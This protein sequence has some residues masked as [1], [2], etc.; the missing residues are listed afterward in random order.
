MTGSTVI[1]ALAG[2]HHLKLP[3]SDLERSREWY[4]RVLGYRRMVEFVEDGRLM[5]LSLDHP[6]GGPPLALRL[7]PD[8]AAAVAGFDYFSIGVAD[9]ET[10]I[11]IAAR[12]D[13]FGIGHG[14]VHRTTQGWV[15]PLAHDPDGHEVRFYTVGRHEDAVAPDVPH[16]I[17]DPGPN[18]RV[19][20]I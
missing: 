17:L 14:G 2:L 20:I 3:V 1:P 11:A 15:L 13:A 6:D 8:R 4:E 12:L 9:E 18:A 7:D 16:R 10:I 5:G 19:E